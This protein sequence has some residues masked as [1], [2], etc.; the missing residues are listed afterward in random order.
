M[1]KQKLILT[2]DARS[3]LLVMI[4]SKGC[5]AWKRRRADCLLACDASALGL[6]WPD[7]EVSQAYRCSQRSVETWRK[8]AAGAGIK[9]A[10]SRKPGPDRTSQRR[11]TGEEEARLAALACSAPPEGRARWTLRLL[12]KRMVELEIVSCVSH[13]S[14]RR[15]LKKTN[16]SLGAR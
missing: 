12:S 5:P 4:S 11:L 8:T 13:E 9:A 15:S 16:F 1:K 2:E 3:E 14:V 7:K 6:G 10:L